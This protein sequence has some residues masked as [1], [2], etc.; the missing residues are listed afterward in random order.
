MTA[1]KLPFITLKAALKGGSYSNIAIDNALRKNQLSDADAGLMTA[2]VMGVTE[3]RLTLDHIID[4]LSAKPEKVDSDTRVLLQTGIYQ[5]LYME[6]IPEYAAVNETVDIAPKRSAGF[7][8]AILRELLRRK[9]KETLSELFPSEDTDPVGAL[10]VGYSFPRDACE[11]FL[12]IYGLER[13]KRIFEIFNL[14]PKLT[15]RINTLKIDRA[16][17][18]GLLEEKGIAYTLSERLENSILLENVSFAAL[19]GFEEGYF[20]VQDEA[21][22]ICVEAID[23]RPGMLMVDAC[24]CPGSK[25]FG[26]AVKMENQGKILSFDLHA[27]KLKLI[28]K[29]AERLGI[30]VIS[31]AE[32]DGRVFDESLAEQADRVLCDVPC[33]GLGV[34]AKKPEIRYKDLSDFNALPD[35]QLAILENCSRYVKKG[36]VLVYSTCTVLPKENG[37]NV[38]RFLSSHPE[39]ETVDFTVGDLKSE[40]GMLSLSPDLHGTD[41]FFVAKF[42]RK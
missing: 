1:R 12:N 8:N 18:A 10:S 28:E 19:P 15:L 9:K 26:S 20:F 35:I 30:G 36:G 5:L 23:A 6:R 41:G 38:A 2:I 39:F 31:V 32:R 22:Q 7:V 27:S 4:R 21:S 37:E 33:S 24:S 13:T 42:M 3:R 14:P 16:S 40:N 25:S 29:S 17:Y 34:I 11:T